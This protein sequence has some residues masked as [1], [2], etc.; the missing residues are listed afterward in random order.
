[1]LTKIGRWAQ[2]ALPLKC[3]SPFSHSRG[4]IGCRTLT[5][6]RAIVVMHLHYET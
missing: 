2:I 1:M 4:L 6:S 3:N 5:I